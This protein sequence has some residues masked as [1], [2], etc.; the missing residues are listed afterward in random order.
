MVTVVTIF[1]IISPGLEQNEGQFQKIQ[2]FLH[3][4]RWFLGGYLSDPISTFIDRTNWVEAS[5]V[6]Q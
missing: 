4:V 3:K 5:K 2:Y 6:W 1:G